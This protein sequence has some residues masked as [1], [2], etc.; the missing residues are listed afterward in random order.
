MIELPAVTDPVR[1]ASC[2]GCWP[3]LQP[4]GTGQGG[5]S[6]HPP[7]V[8]EAELDQRDSPDSAVIEAKPC[9]AS[10]LGMLSLSNAALFAAAEDL[11]CVPIG[12]TTAGGGA[13]RRWWPADPRW[14]V[15]RA[16]PVFR[17]EPHLLPRLVRY[18]NRYPS[19]VLVQAP[20]SIGSG[21]RAPRADEGPQERGSNSIWRSS[22]SR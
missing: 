17:R 3:G 11:A 22:S 18:F 2:C 10:S 4:R 19:F 7:P 14:P 9:P 21:S 16:Q 5:A 12:S 20:D 13:T 1:A 15:G 6:G 8:D